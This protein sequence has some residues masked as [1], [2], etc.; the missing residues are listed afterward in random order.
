MPVRPET[1]DRQCGQI[2]WT[3]ADHGPTIIY[4]P[5]HR[6]VLMVRDDG[7]DGPRTP[8]QYATAEAINAGIRMLQSGC[9][10]NC[11]QGRACDCAPDP[12]AQ[13]ASTYGNDDAADQ[14]KAPMSDTDK[15]LAALVAVVAVVVFIGW[16]V[17]LARFVRG[18]F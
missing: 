7:G 9:T 5:T 16:A 18:L 17:P 1:L 14:I 11:N 10:G 4:L 2:T 8:E 12:G 6:P 15:A 3:K 13:A